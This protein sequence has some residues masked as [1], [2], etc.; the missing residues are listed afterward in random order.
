MTSHAREAAPEAAASQWPAR[1]VAGVAAV[2]WLVPFF[3]LVDL[4]VV[5]LHDERF[6]AYYVLE[7]SWG[8]LYTALVAWPLIMFAVRPQWWTFLHIAGASGCAILIVGLVG[9]IPGQA[10]VGAL[11]VLSAAAPLVMSVRTLWPA[12]RPKLRAFPAI[13]L[14]LATIA[15]I[16]SVGN[17]VTVVTAIRSNAVDDN[18]WE[19][20]HLPM[21]A[22]FGFAVAAAAF[23]A[24]VARTVGAR[25]SRVSALAPSFSAIWFGSVCALYPH[26]VGSVGVFPSIVVIA[27]GLA[28]AAT[29][30]TGRTE[31]AL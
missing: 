16:G 21:Q 12:A 30:W 19:L 6:G 29:A 8:L 31:P 4:L 7:T 24:V 3:G 23:V 14:I 13:P 20:M 17:A 11:I 28:F 5:P 2:L 1:T 15:A 27:W 18:T 26:L 25:G 9:R 10:L 22:A